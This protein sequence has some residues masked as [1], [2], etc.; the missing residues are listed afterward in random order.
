M[1]KNI[2]VKENSQNTFYNFIESY[3]LYTIL[4]INSLEKMNAYIRLISFVL[5]SFISIYYYY[6]GYPFHW[7]QKDILLFYYILVVSIIYWIYKLLQKNFDIQIMNITSWKIL[8]IFLW[9]L[10]L[11]C[12]FV[13]GFVGASPLLW[14]VF[15]LKLFLF[16]FIIFFLWISIFCLWYT[17]LDYFPIFKNNSNKFFIFLSSLW[18][19]FFIFSLGIFLLAV[20]WM[21]E[22]VP[23]LLWFFAT[24]IFSYRKILLLF[25]LFQVPINSYTLSRDRDHFRLFVDEIHLW[26]TTLLLGVNF[27]SIYRPFPIGW[28][29]LWVYMNYPKL[30][31]Q[32]GE[33]ISLGQ[34]Q[35][36]QLYVGIWHVF[37]SQTFS[38]FLNSFS[39]ILL[40]IVT[41]ISLNA[42]TNKKKQGF[43][44]P[45]FCVLI[46]LMMPM[47]I[48]QLAKDM[49]LD[50]GLLAFSIIPLSIIYHIVSSE[51]KY[52]YKEGLWVLSLV[53]LLIWFAFSVKVI[54]LFLLL[55]IL[56]V[57]VYR[58]FSIFGF[59]AF[60]WIFIWTFT[61]L[62]LWKLINVTIPQGWEQLVSVISILIWFFFLFLSYKLS[63]KTLECIKKL[64]LEILVIFIWFWI[65]LSPWVILHIARM[66]D[67]TSFQPLTLIS[68]NVDRYNPDYSLLY[69]EEEL[70]EKLSQSQ[71][72]INP[73][74]TTKDEDLW[75]Y[76]GYEKGINNYLKLPW[77]LSFQLNQKGEFTDITYIFLALI[78]GLLLFLP[79]RK[80]SY[81]Y[82]VIWWLL[83]MFIY[84]IPHPLGWVINEYF[85][86]I[87]LP[88]GYIYILSTFLLPLI[89]FY[90]S[91]DRSKRISQI[92]LANYVFLALYM[93]LWTISSFGIVWYGIVM[94]FWL[95]VFI[96]LGILSIYKSRESITLLAIYITLWTVWVYVFMSS[97]PHAI[98]N[99]KNAG[100]IDYKLGRQ[101]EEVALIK[102]HPEYFSILFELNIS[103]DLHDKIFKKYR[104]ELLSIIDDSQELSSLTAIVQSINNIEDLHW[105]IKQLLRVDTWKFRVQIE[106]LRQDMYESV[107]YV[108]PENKNTKNIFRVGTFLKYFI[109]ENNKRLF[110]DSLLTSFKNYIE[111]ENASYTL[112]NFKKLDLSYILL[113]LNAATIDQ[114]PERRLTA[115]YEDMLRFSAEAD[116][117]LVESDSICLKLALDEYRL[118][119]DMQKYLQIAWVNYGNSKEKNTKKL[120][121]ISQIYKA[122]ETNSINAEKY[123]YL[124]PY[125]K[126]VDDML[127]KSKKTR[128]I[129]EIYTAINQN[130]PT[131]YKVLFKINK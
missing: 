6:I 109:S 26:I 7:E 126:M 35:T 23:I 124:R 103:P 89:F 9:H 21:Y 25:T 127:L 32:A 16:L 19:G 115:R 70:S 41:Y 130:L 110:E 80:D 1:W 83:F 51:E 52:S 72:N 100:Y 28:D 75:R 10:F 104:N 27:I 30:L 118:D 58:R 122:I 76:F 79:Y 31:A 111:W 92:F 43:D 94:Y 77:N 105:I 56:W 47:T 29:D 24:V 15:F 18:L 38:F 42:L 67:K 86:D 129:Q 36:W 107:I 50:Y 45:L 11:L 88:Q 37:W 102:F 66:T 117:E 114:D 85:S 53:G 98:T 65:A 17:V 49:K 81:I 14:V 106:K 54:S 121:C 12:L 90:F 116:L 60:L 95:L 97:V 61:Y 123:P 55:G 46:I 113:D 128:T 2:N 131:W 93:F 48:F 87:F 33:L 40:A 44:I 69:W 63:W 91:L 112:E 5:I 82:I 120:A 62:W 101:S 59:F 71:N 34:M 99:L 73:S 64:F 3:I 20:W 22:K 8:S 4:K 119:S 39:W 125:K 78:P 68:W 84:F 108:A 96:L 13:F 57:V 74:G